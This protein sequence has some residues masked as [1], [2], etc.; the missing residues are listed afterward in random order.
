[1]AHGFTS[2]GYLMLQ[3]GLKIFFFFSLFG[4]FLFEHFLPL[5]EEGEI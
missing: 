4:A 5:S 1:M 3:V 2:L